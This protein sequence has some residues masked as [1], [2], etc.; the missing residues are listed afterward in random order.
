MEVFIRYNRLTRV[1]RAHRSQRKPTLNP[2]A[3][4]YAFYT[5]A[6]YQIII[7]IT[8]FQFKFSHGQLGQR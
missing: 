2:L 6:M 7:V 5:R 1:N 3:Y 4:Q 8:G